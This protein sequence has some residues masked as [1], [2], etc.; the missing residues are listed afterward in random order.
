MDKIK[1]VNIV[2]IYQV[3]QTSAQYD[4]SLTRPEDIIDLVKK[5]F[6]NLDREITAVVGL[7][8]CNVPNVINVVS[9]GTID[10]AIIVPRDVFKALILSNSRAFVLFHNHPA[11]GLIPSECDKEIT[12]RLLDLG[13]MM[14]IELLD[15]II[16]GYGNDFCSF[17][18]RNL[19]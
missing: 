16:I 12:K 6:A 1:N 13:K 3:R 11:G 5:V 18:Q 15:H 14:Q 19:I 17:R 2:K 4:V 7:N 10:S 8:T 9:T